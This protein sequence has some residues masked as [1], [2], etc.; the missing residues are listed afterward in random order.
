MNNKGVKEEI[1]FQ[2]YFYNNCMNGETIHVKKK[3]KSIKVKD[4]KKLAR[5]VLVLAITIIVATAGFNKGYDKYLRDQKLANANE[6]MSTK[7]V[8]YLEKSNLNYSVLEDKIIF[9][10]DNEKIKNLVN[11][12]IK[13]GFSRDEV[14]YMVSQ[15]CEDK[16][17]DNVAQAYGYENAQ[18]FLDK[19]YIDGVLSST[20]QTYYM[21]WGDEDVFENNI[22]SKYVESVEELKEME[23]N[24]GLN[25]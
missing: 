20:G 10:K 1:E 22:E 4:Y 13:D 25:R 17:F 7:I 18:D 3:R 16:E 15:V 11:S 6:Y 21:S 5:S 2:K 14:F 23:E 8:T 24:K 9:E 12:L 19:N